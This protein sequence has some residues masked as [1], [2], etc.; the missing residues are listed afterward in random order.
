MG[1][2]DNIKK[3]VL[4]QQEGTASTA[5]NIGAQATAEPEV[6]VEKEDFSALSDFQ[7]LEKIDEYVNEY[8]KAPGKKT[9]AKLSG[10]ID[11]FDNR[12]AAIPLS[13]KGAISQDWSF[14][15]AQR[16]NIGNAFKYPMPMDNTIMFAEQISAY[17]AKIY[18][19]LCK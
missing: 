14:A 10:I 9:F 3:K 7:V 19:E 17:V 8:K 16:D 2:F 5:Q 4:G 15:K 12:F 1:L 6:K 18:A 13:K 11:E